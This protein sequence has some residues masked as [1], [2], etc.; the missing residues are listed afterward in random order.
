[1]GSNY[2]F[3]HNFR[4]RNNKSDDPGIN[5]R[6]FGDV[7]SAGVGL[8]GQGEGTINLS[9]VP[10]NTYVHNA[11][12]YWATLGTSSGY[13]NPQLDG[14]TVNGQLIGTSA[15]TC[16]GASANYVFRADVT[17]LVRGNGDY[18][19]SGLPDDLTVG[20]DSQGASLVVVYGYGI[21]GLSVRS[22][23]MMVRSHLI[24][25]QTATRTP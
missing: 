23:L 22:S 25:L 14:T 19:I 13:A 7:T 11:F 2:F 5:Q 3:H 12:L 21:T 18:T 8:R 24:W 10:D 17:D 6:I 9:G 1:M 16:W 15:D 4:T 20:N